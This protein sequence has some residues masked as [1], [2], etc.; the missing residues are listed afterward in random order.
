MAEKQVK[1][2][3]NVCMFKNKYFSLLRDSLTVRGVQKELPCNDIPY[4]HIS[5]TSGATTDKYIMPIDTQL[6]FK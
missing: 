4:I 1:M 3:L 2:A 5:D 6:Q